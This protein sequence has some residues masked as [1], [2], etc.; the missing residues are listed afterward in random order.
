MAKIEIEIPD[1]FLEIRG[2]LPE[3]FARKLR[4]AAPIY[5]YSRTE[6]SFGR[7]AQIAGLNIADFIDLLAS[8]KVEY[9][10]EIEDIKQELELAQ[11]HGLITLPQQ[12]QIGHNIEFVETT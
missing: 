7:A 9:P 5:W 1:D 8:K 2:T 11:A 4:L 10:M 3:E 12:P 6:I